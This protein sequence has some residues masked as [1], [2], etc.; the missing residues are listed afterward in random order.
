[1]TGCGPADSRSHIDKADYYTVDWRKA[2][3]GRELQ[4]AILDWHDVPRLAVVQQRLIYPF[5]GQDSLDATMGGSRGAQLLPDGRAAIL[6]HRG[7]IMLVD[8]M[9]RANF[10]ASRGEGP[11]ELIGPEWLQALPDGRIATWDGSLSRLSFFS[12]WTGESSSLPIRRSEERTS[13]IVYPKAVMGSGTVLGRIREGYPVEDGAFII[14]ADIAMLDESGIPRAPLLRDVPMS[15]IDMRN[16]V[17]PATGTRMFSTFQPPFGRSGHLVAGGTTIC[18][19][20]TGAADIACGAVDGPVWTILRDTSAGRPITERD[21]QYRL[22]SVYLS[23][24][25]PQT[26]PEQERAVRAVPIADSMPRWGQ[27]FLD[28]DDVLWL[29]KYAAIPEQEQ[30]V[31]LIESG[32]VHGTVQLPARMSFTGHWEINWSWHAGTPMGCAVSSF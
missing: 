24:V 8:G 32:R 15:E 12:P 31:L 2:V 22:D 26:W 30:Q 5:P 17:N 27:P 29:P 14:R 13:R 23:K 7:Y 28:R 16:A 1:M 25:R 20:W 4:H 3:V 6:G 21:Y 9:G 18:Y 10:L 19:I 11:G